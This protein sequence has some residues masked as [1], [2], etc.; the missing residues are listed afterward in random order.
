MV[1]KDH[2]VQA[3]FLELLHAGL[4]EADVK[5]K[6]LFPLLPEQ[7]R[8]L[9]LWQKNKRLRVLFTR[10]YSIFR[11]DIGQRMLI[12]LWSGPYTLIK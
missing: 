7:W 10:D 5:K 3:A 4:W 9:W 8:S 1:K 12:C 2:I 11:K 6:E